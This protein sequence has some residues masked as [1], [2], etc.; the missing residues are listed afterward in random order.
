M[1]EQF[2]D[3]EIVSSILTFIMVDQRGQDERGED[4]GGVYRDAIGSFWQEFYDLYLGEEERVP[5]LQHDFQSSEW[6]AIARVIVKGYLDLQYFPYMLSKAFMA[7]AFFSENAVSEDMLLNSFMRY[8]A[9]DEMEIISA[10]LK[11][12]SNLE[13]DEELLDLLD[14]FGCRKIPTK[15]NVRY[16]FLE[17]A[18]KELIQKAQYVADSWRD[19]LHVVI[20]RREEASTVEGLCT[21]Y[22]LVESTNRKV[23][24]LLNATPN[25]TSER[26]AVDVLKRYIRGLD[27]SKLKLFLRFITGAD[28]ICVSSIGVE[29]SCLEGLA[30][31]PIAHTCGPVLELPS[32][33][34]TFPEL[35]EEFN[36]I[37]EKSK[38]QNDS[39]V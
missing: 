23:L 31:R 11:G 38:W 17:I 22:N 29:F 32:T 7:S 1:I 5:N 30:R 4:V 2:K 35:C 19:V 12:E 9:K 10:V 16:L 6:K 8:V 39:V 37:L 36:N 33:Y 25:S 14:R 18:H 20:H 13:D 15:E 28:V 24:Q 3:G 26:A 27:A 34:K 21:L